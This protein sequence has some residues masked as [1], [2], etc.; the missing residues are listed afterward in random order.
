MYLRSICA[1]ILHGTQV[2]HFFAIHNYNIPIMFHEL[3]VPIRKFKTRHCSVSNSKMS[4]FYKIKEI[5]V[6]L[7]EKL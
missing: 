2:V 3:A 5:S 6:T 1:M 4:N 7:F